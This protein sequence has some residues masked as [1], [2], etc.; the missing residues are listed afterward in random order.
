MQRLAELQ[1]DI[2][3]DIDDG[4][5]GS[6]TAALEPLPHP[7]WCGRLRIDSRDDP[8]AEP[9]TGERVFDTNTS[10]SARRLGDTG[11]R[12]QREQRTGARG[13]IARHANEGKTIGPVRRQLERQHRIVEVEHLPQIAADGNACIQDQQTGGIVG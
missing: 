11:T 7:R 9:G 4:G 1:H 8:R 13:E 2:G 12:R 5:D 10:L 3:G 6:N